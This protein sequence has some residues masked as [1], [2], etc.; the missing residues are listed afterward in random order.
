MIDG[1]FGCM[2]QELRWLQW[3]SMPFAHAPAGLNL[4][5][6]T[7]L[8]FSESTNLASLWTEASGDTE[9]RSVL[10]VINDICYCKLKY[11]MMCMEQVLQ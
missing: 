3:K 10:G 1:D 5:L 7:S 6:V 9:V 2:S 11:E 8:D 4:S